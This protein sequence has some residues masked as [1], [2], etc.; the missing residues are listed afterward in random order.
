[1]AK[2][3][4][5]TRPSRKLGESPDAK[6]RRAQSLKIIV[7]LRVTAM[8]ELLYSLLGSHRERLDAFRL[9]DTDWILQRANPLWT[10][11]WV[12][13]LDRAF[14]HR[15]GDE[16]FFVATQGRPRGYVAKCGPFPSIKAFCLLFPSLPS[17]VFPSIIRL[18]PFFDS[19]PS[20]EQQ[21]ALLFACETWKTTSMDRFTV[22]SRR[23]TP[24]V[25]LIFVI[26]TRPRTFQRH[27]VCF[28]FQRFVRAIRVISPSPPLRFAT[29]GRR[30]NG[31]TRAECNF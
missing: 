12:W 27:S 8:R 23:A 30:R 13:K 31:K 11:K 29:D 14:L 18:S 22:E 24:S 25:A 5:K 15:W 6:G 3:E 19:G 7:A 17:P 4:A 28:N 10:W 20:P 9:G 26:C 1:M 16:W 2:V 21:H